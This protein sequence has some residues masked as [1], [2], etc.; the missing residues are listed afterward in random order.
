MRGSIR[1]GALLMETMDLEGHRL[2]L[3]VLGPGRPRRWPHRMDRGRL[4]PR[5]GDERRVRRGARRPA[6]RPR[7]AGEAG[8][9]ARLLDRMGSDLRQAPRAPRRSR[10]AIR[11]TRPRG[12][13]TQLPLTQ[14]HLAG[15][16]GATRE[17]VN[18]ALGELAGRGC[19]ER[20]RGR[21][22][23]RTGAR[24]AAP[25]RRTAAS[26]GC[27]NRSSGPSPGPGAR[28]ARGFSASRPS[29]SPRRPC[30][31]V[32]LAP[33]WASFSRCASTDRAARGCTSFRVIRVDHL[34]HLGDRS[35]AF[36]KHRHDLRFPLVSVREVLD[37]L[38]A[39]VEHGRAVTR[40]DR[41]GTQIHESSK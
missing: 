6:G 16:T 33:S 4:H 10:G 41:P 19:I 8:F 29:R 28:S 17:S 15:L 11:P 31:S 12:T 39:S 9:L 24:E 5:A 38:V 7:Q 32:P 27:M 13:A 3:D 21:Y 34:D 1:R 26:Q 40:V 37:Q 14:E 36:C 35:R 22:V 30:R 20:T 23:V 18:R 2:V 25:T